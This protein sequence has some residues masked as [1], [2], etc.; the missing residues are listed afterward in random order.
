M[1]VYS[2]HCCFFSCT[3]RQRKQETR[4]HIGILFPATNVCIQKGLCGLPSQTRP[5]SIDLVHLHST[6]VV[7][8]NT[9]I[10]KCFYELL[11]YSQLSRSNEHED[12]FRRKQS[13][14]NKYNNYKSL[15]DLI[16][17][18]GDCQGQ[19]GLCNPN[20]FLDYT[21]VPYFEDFYF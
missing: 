5:S 9:C 20:A 13:E 12:G 10:A 2:P 1:M 7:S 18:S 16:Q 15:P 6:R 17:A 3:G 4:L 8:L 21:L 11:M 19:S 14:V